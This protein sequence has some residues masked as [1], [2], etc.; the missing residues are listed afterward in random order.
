MC[1]CARRKVEAELAAVLDLVDG[2]IRAHDQA[3]EAAS[4]REDLAMCRQRTL[5]ARASLKAL[6]AELARK[7]H[8]KHA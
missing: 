1:P 6:R 3:I 8:R 7:A 2:H 5:T 4:A